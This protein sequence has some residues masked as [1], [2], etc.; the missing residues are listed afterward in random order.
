MKQQ[1][2]YK[3]RKFLI[4]GV[5]IIFLLIIIYIYY[6]KKMNYWLPSYITWKLTDKTSGINI[7][8]PIEIMFMIVDHFEPTKQSNV[9]PW[10]EKYPP[11]AQNY[12][13]KD[14]EHPKYCWFFPIEQQNDEFVKEISKLCKLGI[15]EIQMHLHHKNDNSSTLVNKIKDGIN[16]YSKFGAFITIN[17]DIHFGFIH[18]NWSLDNA[19]KN[20]DRNYCG[21]DNELTILKSL[22]CFADFTFPATG[23]P[24]QPNKINS[25]YY[26]ID[27][28]KLSKSY[29]NGIDVK[30]GY[31][32]NNGLMIIQGPLTIDWHAIFSRGYPAIENGNLQ[33]S[34]PPDNHRIDLWVNAG[35]HIKYK[36]NWIFIKIY[37]H[38]A[39]PNNWHM[40]LEN[41]E[42]EKIFLYLTNNYNDG[43]RYNLHYV[44]AREAYNIIKAAE[45]GLTGD[46][47]IYRN[48][49]I[50]PYKNQYIENKEF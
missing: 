27:N 5:I 21:V 19:I 3:K 17:D 9:Y 34:Q 6:N 32:Y 20:G 24:A 48:Y 18:G 36:P 33:L 29:N 44:T 40:L 43:V 15:G 41:G 39:S 49:I 7:N 31:I 47:N 12:V 42:L 16:R 11:I 26:A 14:G 37:T 46:P 30:N 8:K 28:P 13:D 50:K 1:F 10:I 35:I 45:A 38:G 2:N 22:G 23:T 25:I 4:L